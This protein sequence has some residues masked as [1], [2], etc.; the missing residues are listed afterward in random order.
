MTTLLELMPPAVDNI[1]PNKLDHI[2]VEDNFNDTTRMMKTE[3]LLTAEIHASIK[4][5]LGCGPDYD[6]KESMIIWELTT[7][8]LEHNPESLARR[9]EGKKNRREY[10]N[11]LNRD[12]ERSRIWKRCNRAIERGLAARWPIRER[13]RQITQRQ[14]REDRKSR[15]TARNSAESLGEGVSIDPSWKVYLMWRSS[16][17]TEGDGLSV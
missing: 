12:R 2:D 5:S 10:Y 6:N 11:E 3:S 4:I 13:L 15:L 17:M 1:Y 16:V 8:R 9:R 14:N 7:R